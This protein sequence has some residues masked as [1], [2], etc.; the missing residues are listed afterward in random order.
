MARLRL[1]RPHTR[2]RES[3]LALIDE[4]GAEANRYREFDIFEGDDFDIYVVEL[5]GSEDAAYHHLW[6]VE[7]GA[8]IGHV[9]VD[10]QRD[11]F[12]K[13][14]D[15]QVDYIIRPSKRRQGYGTRLLAL[16]KE[17]CRA[18]GMSRLLIS[19]LS[20]NIG[21]RRIILANGGVPHGAVSDIF[22][23]TRTRLQ[24][25]IDL[26]D[27][28]TIPDREELFDAWAAKYDASV[29]DATFPLIGYE[30]VLDEAIAQAELWD[31]ARA[32]DVGTGTGNLAARLLAG[33]CGEV[34][35]TDFS[36]EMLARSRQ[37]APEAHVVRANLLEAWPDELPE[38]FNRIVSA[39]VFHEFDLETKLRLI[40]ELNA[41]LKPRGRLVIADIAFTTAEDRE[42]AHR[43][44]AGLWD[45][46][47]YYWAADEAIAALANAGIGA[48]YVQVSICGG[49]FVIHRYTPPRQQPP[50][51]EPPF[52]VHK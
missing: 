31:G 26:E 47:E 52:E 20:D 46:D 29:G 3:F 39:Y 8:V 6:L 24:Y 50:S 45:E 34:W 43:R 25:I 41:R 36:E 4:L 42:A 13:Y 16:L 9:Y 19:C 33:G 7:D 5:R 14:R 30:K 44:W 28:M 12:T 18:R 37:K 23:R 51:N 27:T 21:S 10:Y 2:Y 15:G 11:N 40:G 22:G 48:R 35:A 17:H 1:I 32:L 38:Q 49:V